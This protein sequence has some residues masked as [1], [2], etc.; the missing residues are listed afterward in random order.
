LNLSYIQDDEKPYTIG[1]R[2]MTENL[3]GG[4]Y[5]ELNVTYIK[6]LLNETKKML[7]IIQEF[8]LVSQDRHLDPK[9]TIQ[10]NFGKKSL[11]YGPLNTKHH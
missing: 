5:V 4:S 8:D 6:K 9:K 3:K 11:V 10:F 1:K 2:K 7:L